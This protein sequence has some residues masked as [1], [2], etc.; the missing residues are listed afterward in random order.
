MNYCR[1]CAFMER[2]NPAFYICTSIK[3]QEIEGAM[4]EVHPNY[5]SCSCFKDKDYFTN[6]PIFKSDNLW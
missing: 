2:K 6:I 3:N 4:K 1:A 5:E